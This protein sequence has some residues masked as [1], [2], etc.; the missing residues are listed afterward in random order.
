MPIYDY[1]CSK[2]LKE[3]EVLKPI[4]DSDSVEECPFCEKRMVKKVAS[5]AFRI[6][7]Q[8]Y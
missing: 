3:V 8:G 7:N 1:K 6:T 5:P 2:C 4:S